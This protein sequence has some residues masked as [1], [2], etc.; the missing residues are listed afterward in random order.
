MDRVLANAL[1][2]AGATAL[3]N[4]TSPGDDAAALIPVSSALMPGKASELRVSVCIDRGIGLPDLQLAR[5]L[6]VRIF[7]EIGTRIEWRCSNTSEQPIM[8]T[9]STETPE[10]GHPGALAYTQ[11]FIGVI[12]V[13]YDRVENYAPAMRPHLLAYVLAH[14]ITHVLQGITRHSESGIMKAHWDDRDLRKMISKGL[15]F[16]PYDVLLIHR[17]VAA[18]LSRGTSAGA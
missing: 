6:A 13:F 14:E 4:D 2:Q 10:A 7:A 16:T 12:R 5:M 9:M 1:P 3:G 8:V 17:G 15:V 18:P 11:Q